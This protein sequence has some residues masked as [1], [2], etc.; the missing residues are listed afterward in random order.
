MSF[1]HGDTNLMPKHGPGHAG[2]ARSALSARWKASG[3][4]LLSLL[5][6]VVAFS[7]LNPRFSS[8][9]NLQNVLY[10]A[11]VPLIIVVGTTLV[12]QMGSIDLSVQGVMGASGMAWILL[13]PNTRLDLDMAGWSWVL[14]LGLGLAIGLLTGLIYAKLKVPSF[15]V[16]LGT[17]YVGLGIAILLYGNSLL[18]SLTDEGLARWPITPTL[19]L[20]NAFWL[21]FATVVIG[22]LVVRYTY[23]GRGILA[24]GNNET[25]ARSGGM[26]VDRIKIAAFTIAG[27][28]SGLAGILATM[29]LGSGSP[30]IGSSQLF[31]VIPAAVIGGTAL[32]GGEGGVLQSALGVMLLIILNN[33][34]VLAGVDPNY[35]SGVFGA[36]LLI[37]IVAVAWPD[38][39]RLKVEK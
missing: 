21:A 3:G 17:W 31:T 13:S 15:V 25:I 1:A 7:F 9:E 24:I 37:A 38:R 28:L 34:L 6:L 36:I 14:A 27:G 16:T 4:L 18:P 29:Q 30:D 20:P 39:S 22:T 5:V 33:G 23:L 26:A 8:I 10:Q 35:Q 11:S 32:K 2:A 12:I 19:G